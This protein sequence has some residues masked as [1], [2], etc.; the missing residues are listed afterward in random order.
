VPADFRR[1]GL[2]ATGLHW[3]L[4]RACVRNVERERTAIAAKRSAS[5]QLVEKLLEQAAQAEFELG[6]EVLRPP[7]PGLDHEPG[8]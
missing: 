4:N 6:A 7:V 1:R 5:L 2:R 8:P 3:H